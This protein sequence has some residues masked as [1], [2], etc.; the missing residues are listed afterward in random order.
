[1]YPA[2][3]FIGCWVHR[4]I[5]RVC[6]VALRNTTENRSQIESS[7]EHPFWWLERFMWRDTLIVLWILCI[8]QPL[9]RWNIFV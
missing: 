5:V 8:S 6:R 3:D 7:A 1:M 9:Q 2:T 4:A